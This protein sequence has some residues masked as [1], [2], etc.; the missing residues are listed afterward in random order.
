MKSPST[1][2]RHLK[3]LREEVIDDDDDIASRVAYAIE[4][5]V[6]WATENTSG[7]ETLVDQAKGTADLIRQDLSTPPVEEPN[8]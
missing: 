6:R 1:I 2:K 8:K 5:A 4:T 3:Q 7:W